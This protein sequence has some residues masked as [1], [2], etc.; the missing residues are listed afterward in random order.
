MRISQFTATLF[1]YLIFTTLPNLAH[2]NQNQLS[3][4]FGSSLKSTSRSINNSNS[5]I[6]KPYQGYIYDRNQF[7][8]LCEGE[9]KCSCKG[10]RKLLDRHRLVM[11]G[12]DKCF[13]YKKHRRNEQ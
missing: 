6:K 13:N 2:A 12:L 11:M 1:C 9:N 8:I 4:E 7:N 3:S 10:E 5:V